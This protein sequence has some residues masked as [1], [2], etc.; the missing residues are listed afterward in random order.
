L[1]AAA[2]L[3][4][5]VGLLYADVHWNG[6][7][8]GIWLVPLGWLVSLLAAGEVLDL[9]R[10]PGPP[11]SVPTPLCA[12]L[13]TPHSTG[14]DLSL[15]TPHGTGHR[16]VAWAVY[17]GVSLVFLSA[18]V[19]LL[20]PLSGNPYPANCPLGRLGWPLLAMI[21]A[22]TLALVG[23]MR[24]YEQPGGVIVNLALAVFTIVYAGLPLAF[25]VLLRQLHGNHWG[26]AALISVILIVKLSDTGAYFVGKKFGRRKLAPKLSPGKTVAGGVGCLAFAVAAAFLF[27]HIV[28]PWITGQPVG[29]SWIGTVLYGLLLAVIGVIGDLGE[30]LLKRDMGRKDSSSWLPGLGGV[31]DILDSL[32]LA[33]PVAYGC[34]A[35]GLIGP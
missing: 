11:L 9:L 1:A 14:H 20:W 33:F 3:V 18:C 12:G 29:T 19:P 10:T 24:R 30:S 6:G 32:L 25:A 27:A 23:E 2:I 5:L 28:A 35:V 22:V 21:G 15:P 17:L 8:P 16:P 31:L 34:W 13:P 26:L 4:P 7:V